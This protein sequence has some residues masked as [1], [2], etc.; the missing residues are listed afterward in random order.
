MSSRLDVCLSNLSTGL[1]Q[2][3]TPL[4]PSPKIYQTSPMLLRDLNLIDIHTLP[5]P[6]ALLSNLNIIPTHLPLPHPPVLRKSPVLES[7]TALPLHPIMRILVLVPELDRDLVT[8][9]GEELL[10]KPVA[11][12]FIPFP[13]QKID[14]RGGSG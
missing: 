6:P 3:L 11:V 8:L 9:E 5:E 7:I 2:T 13:G 14:D 1:T 4:Q 12:L 10:A